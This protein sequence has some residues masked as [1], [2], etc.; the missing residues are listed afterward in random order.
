M[1]GDHLVGWFG[2]GWVWAVKGNC[3]FTW[4]RIDS[5]TGLSLVQHQTITQTNADLL[6]IGPLGTNFSE[7][8]IRIQNFSFMKMLLKIS[9]AKRQPFC[10]RGDELTHWGRVTH[11]CV[12][13]L[14][15]QGS[16][17][18]FLAGC[19]KS[20]CLCWYRNFLVYWYLKLDNQ[21]VN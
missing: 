13:K 5:G 17:L 11:I 7:I 16:T 6:L 4:V 2:W 14:P 21:V 19:P 10:P 15:T 9:S 12:S 18:S 20:H 1:P 8:L 3:H